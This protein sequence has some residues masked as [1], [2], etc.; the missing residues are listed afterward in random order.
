MDRMQELTNLERRLKEVNGAY[1]EFI[2]PFLLERNIR[3]LSLG[4]LDA[5]RI[6]GA[7]FIAR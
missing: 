4:G 2:S 3:F 1:N 6:R 7:N 5:K